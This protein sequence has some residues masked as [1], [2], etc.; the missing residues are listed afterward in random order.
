[1]RLKTQP[2][3]LAPFVLALLAAAAPLGMAACSDSDGGIQLGTEAQVFVSPTVLA[4]SDV[5]RGEV[6][7]LN[8]EIRHIGTGGTIRLSPIRLETDSPDLSIGLVELDQI[9]PGEVSRIQI[10][11]S[12]ENDPPD[13]GTLVIGHNIVG[14]P[15]TRVSISTPGQR[16][17]LFSAPQVL[18]FG[19]VQAAAPRELDLRVINGGTAPATLTGFEVEGTDAADFSVAIP[20]GTT[21]PVNGEVTLK[22]RY[23]PNGRNKDRAVL[24]LLTEREDVSLDIQVLGEEETPVLTVSPSLVQLGWT[25]PGE[26]AAREL[27]IKNDGNTTL[28][29]DSIRLEGAPSVL[30]L[31]NRPN[32][33]FTLRPGQTIQMGVVFS[34]VDAIPMTENP[35]GTIRFVSNDAARD[36]YLVPIYGAAG[37]PSILVIP[38]DVVDFAFVAEDFTAKRSVVVVNQGASAVTVTGARLVDP[39]TDEFVFANP[40]VLPK[41]LNSGESVELQLTFENRGGADGREYAKF[42]LSTTDPVVPTYPLDVVAG[43]AQRPTCEAAFVPDLLAMGAY[44]PTQK[45]TGKLVVMNTGSGNCEYREHEFDA[46]LATPYG[47]GTMFTCDDRF[48]FNPFKLVST[49][50]PRTI[51]GPGEQLTFELEFTA[52]AIQAALG[53]DSYYA[54][55]MVML[56]DPN[57]S[58]LR[59]VAPPGGVGRGVNVRAESAVPLVT[60]DPGAIDFG[61]VRTDCASEVRQVRVRAEGPI[62]AIVSRAEAVGCG[63]A[64][65]VSGPPVPATVPGFSAIYYDVQFAPDVPVPTECVLRIENDSY[66][67]PV[68]EVSLAGA[69]TDQTRHTDTFRQLPA[70]KVD[71]L[72]VID[73]SFSMGDDQERLR[74]ELPRVM[75]IATSWNQD[76]HVGITTTDT[77]LTKGNFKGFPR[78]ADVTT[79]M[80]AFA[81][82]MVVG[83]AGHYIE[84]GLEA[85]YLALY[86]RSIRTGIMCQD[87]VPGQCPRDDGEGIP[88]I[89]VDNQC[90]GRNY[91]FLRDDAELIVV[92][93]SDEEDSSP[94]TTNWYINRF[95]DLKKPNSGVGV[96]VHSI[97]VTPAGCLAGFGTPGQ[98]YLQVSDAL[99]GAVVSICAPDFGA[100]LERVAQRTFGLKDRF[101]PTLPPDPQTL[102]V[103]VEGQSCTTGW[104]YNAATGAVVFEVD[105]PCYPQ[106]DDEIEIEYDVLCAVPDN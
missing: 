2:A 35:L 40:E 68:Y 56:F 29:V 104:S 100:E 81:E 71:L 86:N 79:D 32:I 74:Q 19:I 61:L 20:D 62:D 30:T 82:N 75:Q 42:F 90:S 46:C 59:F 89:C 65:R 102:A 77:I 66:N 3:P 44:R 83:T 50:G 9:G 53:R 23:A 84:M 99:N 43:R 21:V 34:P 73:D 47:V 96:T 88:L 51:L 5:P 24:T 17:I 105:G 26:V 103:R 98:R 1:M 87:N 106:F 31:T 76:Y 14:N 33:A 85:A 72:Y 60:V 52:P 64:V 69:G 49:P 92:I 38:D 10:V 25:R 93:V 18:D 6:A 39:S 45:G 16:A 8:V 11:Y 57:S 12:S 97:I 41:T 101:Y 67:L 58:A 94:Q 55:L 13:F 28:E 4:F 80:V 27:T 36:P 63:G 91:G 37:E 7:R 48:A 70:P 95:A 78:F 54:R 15:E 22:A